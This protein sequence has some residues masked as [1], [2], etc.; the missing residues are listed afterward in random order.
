MVATTYALTAAALAGLAVAQP[1]KTYSGSFSVHQVR[2][3]NYRA[4]G[5]SAMAKAYL[6]FGAPLPEHLSK[7]VKVPKTYRRDN[8]TG[9]SGSETTTPV[10]PY[11]IEYLTP[12]SIG[13]PAQ[14]L[15]LDFDTGSSDLWVFSTETDASSV[16][17]NQVLYDPSKS[18][19]S[20]EVSGSTWMISYGDGSTSSGNVYTDTVNV[21]GVTVSGQVVESAKTVS[22]S[23]ATGDSDGLLGLAMSSINTVTPTPAK[24]WFDNA[25]SGLDVAAFTADLKYHTAGTYDFGVVDDSKY[26]GELSYVD[27]DD[28]QGFWNF[29]AEVDGTSTEGIAD[30]GTTLLL[31]DDEIVTSYYSQVDGAKNSQADGGYVFSC[32]ATLPDFTFTAGD[33]TITIPGEYI[34]Y[35]PA[36]EAGTSCYGG[37]QSSADIGINIFGDVAL[38]AAFVVF[39]LSTGSPRLG[40]ANK[41][42]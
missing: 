25:I 34:N 26:T 1:V 30:T 16:Q 37:I 13:T 40:W 4:H 6:K 22:D 32:D 33:A 35:A 15:N 29:K 3:N 39:D 7:Y 24:T 19:T 5:P 27:V 23:F 31:I 12:V 41:D 42:L 38:K 2:N 10:G 18:S 11:D 28:S 36:D 17:N 8:T 20:K 21:G 14:T 9:G